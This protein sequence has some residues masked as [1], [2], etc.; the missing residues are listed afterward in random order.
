MLGEAVEI[1]VT[2]SLLQAL[3]GETNPNQS[4]IPAPRIIFRMIPGGDCSKPR[5]YQ[6]R[7][8]VEVPEGRSGS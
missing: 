8:R 7:T 6:G 2:A 5:C 3:R 1:N 4:L